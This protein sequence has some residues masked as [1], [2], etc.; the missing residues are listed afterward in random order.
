VLEGVA[1][2]A[3]EALEALALL[4]PPAQAMGPARA[5]LVRLARE[6][7]AQVMIIVI[8]SIFDFH[9]GLDRGSRP[10][11]LVF[12][13]IGA[14]ARLLPSVCGSVCHSGRV[15]LVVG[16]RLAGRSGSIVRCRRP[17]H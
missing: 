15:P 2:G 5:R 14:D 10:R 9:L 1:W 8:F 6:A 3:L 13:S 17:R 12:L 7:G 16:C 11:W 4:T